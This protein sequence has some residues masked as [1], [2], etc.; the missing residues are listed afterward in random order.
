MVGIFVAYPYFFPADSYLY[1][2]VYRFYP[3]LFESGWYIYIPTNLIALLFSHFH[4]MLIPYSLLSILVF[5]HHFPLKHKL[6]STGWK[7]IKWLIL[8]LGLL[9]MILLISDIVFTIYL[10]QY[11]IWHWYYRTVM[12]FFSNPSMPM[13]LHLPG[14]IQTKT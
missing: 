12:R 9:I 1:F 4:R 3:I 8:K 11:S 13:I 5:D 7:K 10:F 6:Y 14:H 2:F